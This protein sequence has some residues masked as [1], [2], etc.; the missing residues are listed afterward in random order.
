M[1]ATATVRRVL[2]NEV[3][4]VAFV[5]ALVGMLSIGAG[6]AAITWDSDASPNAQQPSITEPIRGDDV[7]HLERN[8]LPV[9]PLPAPMSS[10]HLRFIEENT[11]LGG[12]SVVSAAP[13]DW[14]S[15][16]R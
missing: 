4:L 9:A 12:D 1:Q 6:V 7:R 14:K 13:V 10:E 8:G 2:G 11:L 5:I 16:S 3:R 15:G